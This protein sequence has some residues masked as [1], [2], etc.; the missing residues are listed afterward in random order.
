MLQAN[1]REQRSYLEIADALIQFGAE[2]NKDLAEL[3]RRL[4]FN[5]LI[6][7]T[8]DHLRNHGFIYQ[9]HQGWRLS[10]VYDLNPT[11]AH[12]RPRILSTNINLDDATA[13]LDLALSVA[14]DFRLSLK[15]AKSIIKHIANHV[16][17]WRQVAQISNLSPAEITT[18]AS[19]FDHHDAQFAKK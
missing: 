13:S 17:T 16:Q 5:I 10:P 19:A 12:I 8:D 2:P 1:D 11:P 3:W 6:S 18:M 14:A 7:N 9:R 4:V 15:E